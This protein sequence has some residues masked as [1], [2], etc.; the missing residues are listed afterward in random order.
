MPS[1]IRDQDNLDT[2]RNNSF[3]VTLVR[4]SNSEEIN[5]FLKDE[6]CISRTT[7]YLTSLV[8]PHSSHY[9]KGYRLFLKKLNN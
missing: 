6:V 5:F 8:L 4:L 9:H 7:G 1:L 3:S 2:A